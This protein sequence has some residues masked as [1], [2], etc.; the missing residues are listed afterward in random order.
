MKL[1]LTGE[2]GGFEVR[3]HGT[4]SPGDPGQTSGPPERC[5]PPEPEE[6][7]LEKVELVTAWSDSKG[8]VTKIIDITD[9]V[10]ELNWDAAIKKA[11][12]ALRN[13]DF[14]DEPDEP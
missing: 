14:E 12:E 6:F 7:D 11:D 13:H 8:C 4:Y 5:Y 2:I 9:L 10:Q 3:F 1:E